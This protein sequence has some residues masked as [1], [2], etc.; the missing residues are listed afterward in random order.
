MSTMKVAATATAAT[1]NY[2][3]DINI[4]FVLINILFVLKLVFRK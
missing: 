2:K 3:K 4:M 1:S